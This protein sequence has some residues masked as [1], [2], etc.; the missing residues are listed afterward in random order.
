MSIDDLDPRQTPSFHIK[1]LAQHL[2]RLAEAELRPLGIGMGSLHVLTAVKAGKASTQAELV[3]I[4]QVEQP[5]MA[6]MLSRLE[7]DGL[8]ARQP[9]PSNKRIQ[10]ISLTPLAHQILRS[11]KNVLMK[12]NKLALSD[13]TVDETKILL[14][15]LK[16]MQANLTTE[17]K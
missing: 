10:R 5:S 11:S 1:Q 7:R 2:T 3:R 16:R 15:L 17:S 14:G 13:F 6:Q 12:G 9:E 4:L 8:I